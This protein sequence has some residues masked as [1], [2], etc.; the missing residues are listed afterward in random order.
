MRLRARGTGLEAACARAVAKAL[1][2]RRLDEAP[3]AKFW[4]LS[5]FLRAVQFRIWS[6]RTARCRRVMNETLLGVQGFI[7]SKFQNFS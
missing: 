5:A 1:R 3:S 2:G 7:F 6:A 4:A